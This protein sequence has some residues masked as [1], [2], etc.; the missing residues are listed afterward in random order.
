MNGIETD[1]QT[2][3]QTEQESEGKTRPVQ[4]GVARKCLLQHLESPLRIGIPPL[5]VPARQIEYNGDC[6]RRLEV[7]VQPRRPEGPDDGLPGGPVRRGQ[8]GPAGAAHDRVDG[9]FGG[10]KVADL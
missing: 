4:P 7:A 10:V 9:G 1:R 8:D 5:L 2:D 3:R 6:C